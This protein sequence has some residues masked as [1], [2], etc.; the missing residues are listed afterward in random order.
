MAPSEVALAAAEMARQ[1]RDRQ[2]NPA[3]CDDWIGLVL[4]LPSAL[5]DVLLHQL[6][7]GNLMTHIGQSGWPSPDSIVA[8]FRDRFGVDDQALPPEVAL[9][10]VNDPRQ[11]LENISQIVDGQEHMLMA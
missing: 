5:R 6:D 8:N 7:R 9:Q 11:W 2:S 4:T 3:S 10:V 1:I